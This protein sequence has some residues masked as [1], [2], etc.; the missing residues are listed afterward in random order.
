MVKKRHVSRENG[1]VTQF[2]MMYT[3]EKLEWHKYSD[4]LDGNTD[5]DDFYIRRHYFDDFINCTKLRI[6]PV[7]YINI[8]CMQLRLFKLI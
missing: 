7:Q 5:N 8:K 3:D 2:Y 4:L 1:R 6:Y